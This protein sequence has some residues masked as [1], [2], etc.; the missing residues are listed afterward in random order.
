MWL[1]LISQVTGT[2]IFIVN[3]IICAD[4]KRGLLTFIPILINILSIFISPDH[5]TASVLNKDKYYFLV[6]KNG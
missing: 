4:T 1:G 5:I 6:M 3:R 2:K